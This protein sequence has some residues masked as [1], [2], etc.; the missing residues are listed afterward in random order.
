MLLTRQE[1]GETVV[2]VPKLVAEVVSGS[3]IIRDEQIKFELY[4]REGAAWY[5]LLYPE[6]RLIRAY[7][8]RE[9]AFVK[10]VDAKDEQV[11]LAL[12]DCRLGLDFAR[13]WR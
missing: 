13:V 3:S 1:A 12:S 11:T 4:A 5:L 2:R 10:E 7:R 8:N 6:Q 9:G